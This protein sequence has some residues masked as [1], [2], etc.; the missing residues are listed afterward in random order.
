MLYISLKKGNSKSIYPS[1][2]LISNYLQEQINLNEL[3]DKIYS[4]S[5]YFGFIKRSGF[6]ISLEGTEFLYKR[7]IFS[8]NKF[9]YVTKKGEKSILY[10][11][12]ILKDMVIKTPSNL[13]KGDFL[14]IFNEMNEILGIAQS[15]VERESLKQFKPKNVIAINLSD[16]GYYLRKKQ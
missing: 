11:N 9:V 13:Q 6:Y 14:I 2:Y 16:K 7:G 12:D 5:L 3:N 15:K 10:G 4:L 8:D 1:I